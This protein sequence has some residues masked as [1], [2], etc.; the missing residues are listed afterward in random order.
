[1]ICRN[2]LLILCAVLLFRCGQS[3]GGKESD[4]VFVDVDTTALSLEKEE[5]GFDLNEFQGLVEAYEDPER[6]DWQNPELVLEKLG[7][8]Q[9][10]VVA[11][12]GA[13]TGYFTFRMAEKGAT[14]IA[15]DID[16]RFLGYIDE[17]KA[18]LQHI[19]PE[20]RVH[21]RASLEDDPLLA[22]EEA[23]AAL[24]VNTY[25][26]LDDRVTYLQK[27]RAGLKP[28]GRMVIVDYKTG[29]MPVGPPEP[30][31]IAPETVVEELRSAGFGQVEID[32][33]G[34][35]FQYIISA[36]KKTD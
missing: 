17:R 27:V 10:K 35:Q 13:G 22:S 25:H 36:N 6:S 28:G 8:L 33:S 1:M 34:L 3:D 16:E 32:Q 20:D 24:L 29:E 18:E 31:K 2:F 21:T 11:D 7:D 12:I 30:L 14:V 9:G 26:F 15:I 23:D 19:I 4:T 5:R